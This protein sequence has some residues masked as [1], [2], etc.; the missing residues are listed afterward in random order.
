MTQSVGTAHRGETE[1]LFQQKR[2]EPMRL[3]PFLLRREK[4]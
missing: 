4:P 1:H 3:L 2:Q